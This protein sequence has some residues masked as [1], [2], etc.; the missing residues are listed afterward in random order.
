MN[1][2]YLILSLCFS[3][4]MAF[5][6]PAFAQQSRTVT[7]TIVDE[8]G[9]AIIG[10]TVKVG[11]TNTGTITDMDGHFKLLVPEKGKLQISYVG[12]VSQI[13]TDLNNP[14]IVLK[15]DVAKLDEIVVV[16]YGAQKMKN[17]TGS[18]ATVSA[19]DV[20]DLSVSNLSA[21]LTGMANGL[22]VSGGSSRPG[23]AAS[24]TV[25]Q[26]SVMSSLSATSTYVPDPSPLYVIDDYVCPDNTLFNNLDA[27]AIE[28]ISVLKDAS[29]AVYGSRAANGLSL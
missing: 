20:S 21:A 4:L 10:A 18:V 5:A 19:K 24:L 25:R 1:R 15:E 3:F 22:S 12:Y 17:V 23:D 7:G 29:A 11:G 26:A 9:V 13:V 6:L 16:G 14:H 8:K 27:S 2:R 28:S